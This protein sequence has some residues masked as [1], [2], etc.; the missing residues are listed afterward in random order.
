MM[1]LE[2][3]LE[4][5]SRTTPAEKVDDWLPKVHTA[6][7]DLKRFLLG[8]FHGVSSPKLQKY[9]DEFVYRYIRRF[10]EPQLRHRLLTACANHLRA[11]PI[12]LHA[13]GGCRNCI[14]EKNNRLRVLDEP[15]H[16]SVNQNNW[17]FLYAADLVSICL[18]PEVD[19][20]WD[21]LLQMPASVLAPSSPIFLSKPTPSNST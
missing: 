2:E 13:E 18:I 20:I 3:G 16:I 19:S 1:N 17:L 10:W 15:L 9:L 6:I 14:R 4:V 21:Q 12:M 8:T 11:P 5:E 7:A